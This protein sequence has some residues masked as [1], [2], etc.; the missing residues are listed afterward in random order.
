MTIN[1]YYCTLA[2]GS[3][4]SIVI[5]CEELDGYGRMTVDGGSSGENA[6]GG[7]GGRIAL[8]YWHSDYNGTISTVG[9]KL[10]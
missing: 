9:G 1:N 6:G 10:K 5:E 4:G 2:A 8:Y 3:G 7:S